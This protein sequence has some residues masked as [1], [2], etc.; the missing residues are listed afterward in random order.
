MSNYRIPLVR[1]TISRDDLRALS[2]WLLTNPRLSK[3]PLCDD[4][5]RQF[6]QWQG[7]RRAHFVNSGSSANLLAINA[8]QV[9]GTLA[10]GD[11]VIAPA[12]SWTT[13]VA[14]ITQLQCEPVLCDAD[15]DN[16][17][18]SVEHL[19]QLAKTSGAKA[20]IL[21]HVL[22]VPNRMREIAEICKRFDLVLI[23]D[24]CEALG[25]EYDGV[26]VGNFGDLCTF[27]FYFGHH[28]STIEGG[29]ICAKSDE[30][31]NIIRSIRSH[32]W[33]RDLDEQRILELRERYGID[34]FSDKYTFYNPG[35]NFRSTDLNAFLGLKQLDR[36]SRVVD[37]RQRV[38][39]QYQTLMQSAAWRSVGPVGSR[40]SAFA[41]PMLSPDRAALAAILDEKG[42]ETRPLV[43]GSIG[44]QPWYVDRY[45]SV[46]LEVADR[47]HQHGLYVPINPQL[48][49]D[50]IAEICSICLESAGGSVRGS[51]A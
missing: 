39:D 19:E 17:G 6:A 7:C 14:P 35:F 48:S 50:E 9:A 23:E 38:W 44:R 47:V 21:C 46:E 24:C 13:T 33:N 41:W 34:A 32:G 25:S 4:F 12:I 45:G 1:D 16:L 49:D 11:K 30:H 26:R 5:E 40:V 22:G 3:G 28:M 29:M 31:S 42:I 20:L 43:C 10:P 27:S 15:P 8:L 18:L 2:E 36:L 51:V 37:A